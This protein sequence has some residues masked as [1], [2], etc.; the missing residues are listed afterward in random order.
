[1]KKPGSNSFLSAVQKTVKVN[2]VF[3][4]VALPILTVSCNQS[5]KQPENQSVPSGSTNRTGAVAVDL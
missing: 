1:M 3:A 2:L 4:L 5:Q